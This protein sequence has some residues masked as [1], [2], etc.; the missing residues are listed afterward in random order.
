MK[1]IIALIILFEGN[2]KPDT[3]MFAFDSFLN[4][5]S[6]NAV[7]EKEKE[8]FTSSVQKQFKRLGIQKYLYKC[9][10]LDEFNKLN[11][12]ELGA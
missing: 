1:F 6:C 7:L 11:K 5:E 9:I 12:Q 3:Y 8:F 4:L 2:I 10:T